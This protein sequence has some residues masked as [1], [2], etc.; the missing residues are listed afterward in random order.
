VK[1]QLGQTGNYN[2]KWV[3]Q[4]Q[5]M[6]FRPVVDGRRIA[7]DYQAWI[8]QG[9]K[10]FNAYGFCIHCIMCGIWA[11]KGTH[12]ILNVYNSNKTCF[13]HLDIFLPFYT[14]KVIRNSFTLIRAMQVRVLNHLDKRCVD[15]RKTG[16]VMRKCLIH[17]KRKNNVRDDSPRSRRAATSV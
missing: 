16:M 11:A 5:M 2:G 10:N 7:V 6:R 3:E 15:L 17:L 1:T 14:M 8:C 13:Y 9:C 12:A 4:E